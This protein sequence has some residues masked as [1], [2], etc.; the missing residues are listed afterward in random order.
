[1]AEV[2]H[3]HVQPLRITLDAAQE[4]VEAAPAERLTPAWAEAVVALALA[5]WSE[6]L[7][8]CVPESLD[9]VL[10]RAEAGLAV[11]AAPA[12][13]PRLIGVDPRTDLGVAMSCIA[14]DAVD[15]STLLGRMPRTTDD[16]D[17]APSDVIVYA[18]ALDCRHLD[19]GLARAF[20]P[21]TLRWDVCLRTETVDVGQVSSQCEVWRDS[22]GQAEPATARPK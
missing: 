11:T 1:M 2:L 19:A 17:A 22:A 13:H 7:L 21:S 6:T 12:E 18:A 10:F 8:A 3:R 15:A 5:R 9:S 20:H 14:S 16:L 4:L